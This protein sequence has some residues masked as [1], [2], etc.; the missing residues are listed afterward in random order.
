MRGKALP[1]GHLVLFGVLSLLDLFLTWRLLE[2]HEGLVY[3]SNVVARW[4]LEGYGWLGLAALKVASVL[5]V[6]GLAAWVSRWRPRT[7]RWV[8]TFA[9]SAVALVVVYSCLLA[10]FL[11]TGPAEGTMGVGLTGAATNLDTGIAPTSNVG[12]QPRTGPRHRR[13]A[14]HSRSSL[15]SRKVKRQV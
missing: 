15:G 10:G 8:L 1:T 3:E 14:Y 9:C 7:G 13:R 6:V 11:R 4:F 2:H 5:V 12:H